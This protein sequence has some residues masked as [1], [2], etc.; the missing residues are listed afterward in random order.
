MAMS[1]N[2]RVLFVSASAGAGH[3]QASRAVMA[4]VNQSAPTIETEFIDSLA[5]TPAWFR[6]LYAGGYN[7]AVSRLPRLY[8]LGYRLTDRPET[9]GRAWYE[10]LRMAEERWAARRLGEYIL[11]RRPAMVVATHFLAPP[12]VGRLI[13]QGAADLRLMVV[14]TDNEAHRWWYSEHV[15]RYF[16]S[17]DSVAARLRRWGI[18][19]SRITVSGIPVHPKWSMAVDRQQIYRDWGLREDR[20][21]VIVSGGTYFALGPTERIARDILDRTQA[22]VVVLTGNNKH[23]QA[24]LALHAQANDRL[25]IVPFTDRVN[26]LAEVADL[27]VTKAGGLITSECIAKGVAMVLSKSVP[28]QETANAAMLAEEG[29]AVREDTIQG[30]VSQVAALLGDQ[31][32]LATLR[33]NARR[34]YRPGSQTIAAHIIE[35]IRGAKAD[36]CAP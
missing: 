29:A 35:A 2:K 28:G 9:A 23:L 31:P 22:T 7:L 21:V 10:K 3:N 8:G 1:T 17:A 14:I 4:A 20:P 12:I 36:T 18:D 6:C 24:A 13:R 30:I 32:R 5:L 25:K 26:E 15:E 19:P 27:I 11:S 33:D 34:L 16:V